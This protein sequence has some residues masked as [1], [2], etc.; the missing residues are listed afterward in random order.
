M[1]ESMEKGRKEARIGLDSQED[2]VRLINTNK[3]FRDL[4]KRCLNELGFAI[5]GEIKARKDNM[6]T[7]IFIEDDSKI[8][9][10]IKSSTKTSIRRL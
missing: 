5:Q 2:I 3:Q 1:Y 8:D 4:V 9:V 6:K 7:D 10:S